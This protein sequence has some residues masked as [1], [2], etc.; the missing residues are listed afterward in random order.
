MME[1]EK[2]PKNDHQ[3]SIVLF[4]IVILILSTLLTGCGPSS[5]DLVAVEYAPLESDDWEVSTPKEQ[6]LDPNLV[7]Q[8]H[9]NA[10]KHKTLYGLLVIKNG[11]LIAEGYFNGGEVD[12]RADL[13]SVT[14]SYVSALAGIAPELGCL[15][16][17]DSKMIDFFP[18]FADQ[19]VDPRKAQITI[20]Q[21]LQMRSGYPWE[22]FTPPYLTR[23]FSTGRW[24][25]F[26]V[27]FPLASDP[28][29]TF[30]YSNLTAHLLGVITARSCE[31][32]LLVYAED[33]LFDPM[34]A[35]M[36]TW[37]YDA[38][39]YYFGSG[40]LDLTACDAARFGQLY[41]N[42]GQSQGKQ[43]I[44]ADWV[45]DSLSAYSTGIYN[46]S[47]GDYFRDIG[48]GYLW[49]S[50]RVGDHYFNYAWGHGGNLIILLHELDMVIVT[51]ADTLP[52][53]SGEDSWEKE[54]A[55]IDLVGKFIKSIPGDI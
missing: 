17:L 29:K 50:A 2:Y 6:G 12:K 30:G 1:I 41:L 35:N 22:E 48:Y 19:I 44:P 15:P 32:G 54:G 21:I 4:P 37:S 8:L 31:T 53:L 16:G 18:E 26:L 49:W 38:N 20:E 25:P 14:K 52:G 5:R 45:R 47:L 40:S 36:G 42:G 43:V 51:T 46:D 13:A 39:K 23:L 7:G 9:L 55:I 33:N 34:G 10:A 27:D 11:Y 24:L 28:G 3:N